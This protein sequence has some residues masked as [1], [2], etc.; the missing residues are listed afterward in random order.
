MSKR[1]ELRRKRQEAA[2]RQQLIIIGVVAVA[3]IAI[4]GLLVGPGIWASLQPVGTVVTP[5][6][7]DFPQASGK[8]LGPEDARVLVQE[9]SDFK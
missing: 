2:R 4:A 9:F 5:E 6:P 3:A 8:A 7:E 1:E